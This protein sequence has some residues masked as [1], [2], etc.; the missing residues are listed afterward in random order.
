MK[1]IIKYRGGKSKDIPFFEKYIPRSFD[2]YYEP[3]F[4]GGAVFFYLA[5]NNAAINDINSILIRFSSELKNHY[6]TAREQL[7][8]LQELYEKNQKEYLATL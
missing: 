7:D 6:R 8:E 5:P 2:T 1:P 3:F 4:G